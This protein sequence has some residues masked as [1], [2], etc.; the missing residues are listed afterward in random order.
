MMPAR[1]MP[2][3]TFRAAQ[4]GV[5]IISAIIILLL[6]AVL[7]AYA[8]QMATMQHMGSAQDVESV[9][10]YQAARAG[11]EWALF[12]VQ[13]DN[14]AHCAPSTN[15]GLAGDSFAGIA[16]TVFCTGTSALYQIGAVACNQPTGGSCPN[17]TDFN[18]QYVERRIEVKLR[19]DLD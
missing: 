9:R 15:L 12:K 5:A 1:T 13:P 16:V 19:T 11:I 7:G 17:T 18:S 2:T 8:V 4:A 3:T 6:L 14:G 10:T